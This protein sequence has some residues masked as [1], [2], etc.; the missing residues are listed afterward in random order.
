MSTG[1]WNIDRRSLNLLSLAL[2]LSLTLLAIHRSQ[3]LFLWWYS[4]PRI[5]AAETAIIIGRIERVFL[6]ELVVGFLLE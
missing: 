2:P 3:S 1:V 5:K 4:N 6:A